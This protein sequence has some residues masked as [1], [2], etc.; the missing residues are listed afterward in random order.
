MKEGKCCSNLICKSAFDTLLDNTKD[1]IFIK[2]IN[3]VYVA[4]S[5]PFV[6]MVGKEKLSD[7][8]G[9]T[10]MDIFED[11]SLAKRYVAD[12]KKL[13]EGGKNLVDYI[14][15]ITEENGN[16]RY[17]STS[18]YILSDDDGNQIGILGIT[19]DITRDYIARKHYQRELRYLFELPEDT[20]AVSYIDIDS[21]RV[22]SQRRQ[23]IEG[24]TLEECSS[25]EELCAAAV[26]SIYDDNSK[27]A[28]FYED[29]LPSRLYNIFNSGKSHLSF[30]YQRKMPDGSLRWVHNEVKF[31]IDVDSSHLCVM[32]SAKD[33][34][35]KKKEEQQLAMSAKL[36]KMT[37]LYNR[38]TT[39]KNIRR[40]L[41]EDADK[42]HVLFMIDVDNFKNLNDTLGHQAGDAFLVTLASSIKSIFREKDVVG[43]VGGDEFFVFLRNIGDMSVISRKAN[44]LLKTTQ[45]ICKNYPGI[46]LSGSIGVSLY[47]EVGKD[48]DELYAKADSALYEA[49]RKGK[50][51]FVFAE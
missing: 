27:A 17:G 38:E 3:H 22:I 26:A 5:M 33:I 12:D 32:L 50:N 29:F 30:K 4:A 34:D 23:Q 13:L 43:R 28:R 40:I 15:P 7:I 9:K 49:K 16:A 2:D 36:D 31:L 14:E 44:E 47:P 18:K 11:K 51:Q 48:L 25:V 45:E 39:M 37:M 20:Y 21:W 41:K 19:R 6:H 1:M 42:S 35:A 46:N 10:D 8:I 24:S